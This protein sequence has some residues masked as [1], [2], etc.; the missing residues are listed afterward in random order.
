MSISMATRRRPLLSVWARA[1]PGR[2]SVVAATAREAAST[3]RRV[4][5]VVVRY[6]DMDSL[7][8]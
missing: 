5:V 3:V 6:D 2:V 1:L 8:K 4:P 7:L